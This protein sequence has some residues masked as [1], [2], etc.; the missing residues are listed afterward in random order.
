MKW[1][2]RCLPEPTSVAATLWQLTFECSVSHMYRGPTIAHPANVLIAKGPPSSLANTSIGSRAFG[3]FEPIRRPILTFGNC[4]GSSLAMFLRC[5]QRW[6]SSGVGTFGGVQRSS[7]VN[8]FGSCMG[9]LPFKSV[10]INPFKTLESCNFVPLTV[11]T[12]SC[13]FAPLT[14]KVVAISSITNELVLQVSSMA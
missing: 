11:F 4:V 14:P 12:M 3:Q 6:A 13:V 8:I 5:F 1:W 9:F 10:T 7:L 2:S